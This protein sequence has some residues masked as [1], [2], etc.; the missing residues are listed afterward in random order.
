M[1]RGYAYNDYKMAYHQP[2]VHGMPKKYPED[3]Q[4]VFPSSDPHKG[5]IYVSNVEAA[6]NINTLRSTSAM[7][8]R[9]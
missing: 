2:L 8:E 9:V 4:C 3:I 6:E 1:R 7:N 5:A